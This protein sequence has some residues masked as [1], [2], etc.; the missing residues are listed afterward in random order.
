MSASS[1]IARFGKMLTNVFFLVFL[2]GSSKCAPCPHGYTGDGRF[3]IRSLPDAPANPQST[4]V[5]PRCG[6]NN[7][8]HPAATCYDTPTSVLCVCPPMYDGNGIGPHGCVYSNSTNNACA[9]NPCQ[10][11]GTCRNNLFGFHCECPPNTALPLCS[12]AASPCTPNPCQNGGTCV[13]ST[14]A[15]TMSVRSS[16]LKKPKSNW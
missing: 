3:C 8:C 10:N 12:A 6:A 14:R 13:V 5:Y 4:S 16:A 2:Q 11:G 7:I 1:A 15:M 9:S